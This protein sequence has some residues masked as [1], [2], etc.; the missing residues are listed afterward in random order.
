M[1]TKNKEIDENFKEESIFKSKTDNELFTLED[2]IKT[3][4][5]WCNAKIAIKKIE[6][7]S[8]IITAVV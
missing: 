7:V 8:L 5:S 3:R 6:N 1:K 4:P 2:E